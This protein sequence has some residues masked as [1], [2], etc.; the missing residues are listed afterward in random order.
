[1]GTYLLAGNSALPEI[2][3]VNALNA[4][5]INRQNDS[6][7]LDTN[8]FSSKDTIIPG[9]IDTLKSISALNE[10]FLIPPS[11]V[12]IPID[13]R[14]NSTIVYFNFNHFVRNESKKMFFQ[15]WLKEKE[16]QKISVQTD[17]LRKAYSIASIQQKDSIA[18]MIIKSEKETIALNE[19]IPEIYQ[20]AREEENQYWQ[21]ASLDEVAQFQ[22]KIELYKDSMS[23]RAEQHV[24]KETSHPGISDTIT[25]Y[26]P[27]P[28]A[29]E[30][31]TV[32]TGGIIYKIQ[33]GAYKGKIPDSAS[34]LIKK[35][36]AIRKVENYVDDKGV[37]IYTTGN[38]R[39]YNEAETMLAQVKQEGIKNA[40][41]TAYQNGKKTT[42][43][44]AR[45]L[46]N[47]TSHE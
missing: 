20:K 36:S 1:M 30:K 14:I 37:T 28:K 17:S 10:Q 4:E 7:A 44:E 2:E 15:A 38:M 3:K 16:L 34:K 33:I 8:Y 18:S 46:N 11:L 31:K 12:N 24:K 22:K 43:V 6:R 21:S 13:F 5:N 42:V 19:Q 41:I 35:I 39:L 9:R 32:V 23:Q 47:E 45:K 26:K 27:A 29:A 25:L 40:Q